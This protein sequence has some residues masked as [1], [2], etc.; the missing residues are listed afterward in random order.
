MGLTVGSEC[1]HPTPRGMGCTYP[2]T[3]SKRL[4]DL[5]EVT[6]ESVS[7]GNKTHL[8][9]PNPVLQTNMLQI[10]PIHMLYYQSTM[11]N[12]EADIIESNMTVKNNPTYLQHSY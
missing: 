8:Q 7:Y 11:F 1:S 2:M 3:G 6:H 5:P 4:S 10:C 9:T 12:L